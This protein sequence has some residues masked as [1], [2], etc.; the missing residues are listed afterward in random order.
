MRNRG[1]VIGVATRL[2]VGRSGFRLP[3]RRD[4]YLLRDHPDLSVAHPASCLT[5]NGILSRGYGGQNLELTTYLQLVPQLRMH[6]NCPLLPL[7][8]FMKWTGRTLSS[9]FLF[10]CCVCLWFI[11]MLYFTRVASWAHEFSPSNRK[12]K[13]FIHNILHSALNNFIFSKLCYHA[14]FLN[15][16]VSGAYVAPRTQVARLP[17][18]VLIVWN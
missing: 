6:G 2:R 14:S 12:W 9:S 13:R 18:L 7:Y 11:F 10:T 4:L 17:L 16:D 1:V 5:G 8:A 3:L 15:H